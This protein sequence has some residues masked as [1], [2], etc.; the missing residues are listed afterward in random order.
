MLKVGL[1]GG[2]GSGKSTVTNFFAE[3]KIPIIDSDAIARKLITDNQTVFAKIFEHFGSAS[4][5]RDNSI[6]R[7]YLKQIIFSDIKERKWLENLLH[8]LVYQEIAQQLLNIKAPYCIIDIPLLLES[9]GHAIVDRILV[10]TIPTAIQIQRTILRDNITAAEVTAI[11]ENQSDNTWR[12]SQAND[13]IDNSESLESTQKQ[14][15]K[16][17]EFYTNLG[18]G[19]I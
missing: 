3:L 16:L 1:T 15:Q 12:L 11:I 18:A 5:K 10:V 2:I 9:G 7:K 8:P 19:Y 13:I 17:H 4:I 14:V 6:D